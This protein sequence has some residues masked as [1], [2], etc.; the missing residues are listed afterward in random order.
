MWRKNARLLR[1][2]ES[3]AALAGGFGVPDGNLGVAQRRRLSPRSAAN[4]AAESS[5]SARRAS[6]SPASRER[7][8]GNSEP[9]SS[10]TR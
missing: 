7:G 6:S 5:I 8:L 2:P 3:S 4:I 9:L 1:A 10:V